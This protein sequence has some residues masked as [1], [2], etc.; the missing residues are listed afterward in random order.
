MPENKT[1][2]NIPILNSLRFFAAF[3]V[4][5]FHFICTTNGLIYN[6]LILSLFD[7]GRYGVQMF[8]VISGFVIPWSMYNAKYKVKNIF[9]FLLKRLLRLEPPYIFSIIFIILVILI[10]R[11]SLNIFDVQFTFTQILLHFGY[12]IP[13]FED[14]KWLNAVYWTLAIEFQFYLLI[15]ILFP[16]FIHSKS[17]YRY[18]L[19]M[20]FLLLSINSN[21]SLITHWLPI[22]LMGIIL[23]LKMIKK[24]KI[25]EFYSLLVLLSIWSIYF[26]GIACC[27][28]SISTV[29]LIL[30]FNDIELKILSFLGEFSY[31]L[32]LIHNFTGAILINL[33]SPYAIYLWQKILLL[34]FGV[35]ISYVL[36]WMMYVIIEKPSKK[37]STKIKY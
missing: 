36:A 4:C 6:K 7:N 28:F 33:L 21:F 20:L 17:I 23:F 5:I 26:H 12:L 34:V 32:Y 22:F 3:S 19:Y 29:L 1:Y 27:I 31:S 15:S 30:Y 9:R 14:Y 11:K 24:I 16:L 2:K 25:I 35:I 18:F 13:F 10:L 37:L 8:F